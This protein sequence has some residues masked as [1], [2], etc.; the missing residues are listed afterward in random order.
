MTPRTKI[1][2][3]RR[4]ARAPSSSDRHQHRLPHP[5]LNLRP[6][7]S[8]PAL[9]RDRS[10][11]LQLLDDDDETK[12]QESS[13]FVSLVTN[14]TSRFVVVASDGTMLH[15]CHPPRNDICE[16]LYLTAAQVNEVLID[17][18]SDDVQVL[19]PS[20]PATSIEQ[21]ASSATKVQEAGSSNN[22]I[23]A[24]VAKYEEI[25]YWVVRIAA[26]S[27]ELNNSLKVAKY[28]GAL[29][30]PLREFGDR[31]TNTVDAGILAT[32]N[33]LVEFHLSHGFCSRCGSPT[34]SRK[35][36]ASRACVSCRRSVYPRLDVASIMLITSP[37]G[38]YALLGRKAS[39]PAGRYSTL[40]GFQEVGETMEE[41]C[42]RETLEESGV[43]VD[44]TSVQFVA[45]QPWPFPQSLMV[46]FQ[47]RAVGK[48]GSEELPTIH[49]DRDEMQDIQWFSRDYVRERLDGGSTALGFQPSQA[50]AEF[51]IPGRSSLARV[52]I[53]R[54]VD[55]SS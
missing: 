17:R 38:N 34:A 23:L 35:A 47:A 4:T 14:E 30:L 53:T 16:P 29:L 25:D 39:W 33:G 11:V 28:R 8:D 37:C 5:H 7:Y 55:S 12:E 42:I 6:W 10:H 21:I 26:S 46:G 20:S 44:P 32:A 45:S 49:I 31:L 19:Q 18:V 27:D 13:L 40:A 48:S 1:L 51:H 9:D 2:W 24:W 41:C 43:A 22:H 15:Q 50:E 52:L 54:W 3:R 36:G